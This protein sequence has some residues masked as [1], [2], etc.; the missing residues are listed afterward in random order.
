MRKRAFDAEGKH[1]TQW[2]F[3]PI[4]TFI[5]QTFVAPSPL[6]EVE[7]V[8]YVYPVCVCDRHSMPVF[9]SM[10]VSVTVRVGA[11][12]GFVLV[13]Q[14]LLMRLNKQKGVGVGGSM[15]CHS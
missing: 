13:L 8:D 3:P 10:W 1:V 6:L 14:P 5:L 15:I 7:T 4:T 9:L 2:C 11:L 12:R